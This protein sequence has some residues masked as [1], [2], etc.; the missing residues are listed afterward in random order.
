MECGK[1]MSLIIRLITIL[2]GAVA[3]IFY[4]N[5]ARNKE[6]LKIYSKIIGNAFQNNPKALDKLLKGI[7]LYNKPDYKG[8]VNVFESLIKGCVSNREFSVTYFF[9]ALCFDDMSLND[10]AIKAYDKAI[11]IN[12]HNSDAWKGKGLA[13]YNL[14]KSSETIKPAYK[15]TESVST[16]TKAK[17]EI[18]ESVGTNTKTKKETTELASIPMNPNWGSKDKQHYLNGYSQG[19]MIGVI[20]GYDR[21]YDLGIKG[22][23]YTGTGHINFAPK[24]T[25]SQDIGYAGGYNTGYD[26]KFISGYNAGY[27]I[28]KQ[29]HLK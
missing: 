17:N 25:T 6:Y 22:V 29:Q 7:T 11:E 4:Q 20:N 13:L 8:A 3:R 21:G 10:E 27:N 26:M 24:S 5:K 1:Q 14:N 16:N 19:Y 28:Y 23:K 18:T 12:P 2:F 9:L 15:T